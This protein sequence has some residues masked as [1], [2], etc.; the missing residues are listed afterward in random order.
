MHVLYATEYVEAGYSAVDAYIGNVT[1][2]VAVIG[3]DAIDVRVP[4]TYDVTYRVAD[5]NGNVGEA[6]RR[7]VV[8]GR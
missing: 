3:A 1:A 6:V 5:A 4:G 7:V 2:G 8:E